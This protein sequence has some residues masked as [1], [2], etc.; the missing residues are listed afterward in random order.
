[1]VLYLLSYGPSSNPVA[2]SIKLVLRTQKMRAD[3]TAPIYLR[4]TAARKSRF[5]STGIAVEPKHWHEDKQEV[6]RTHELADTYNDRLKA[7]KH[8]A[9]GAVLDART[10]DAA[11]KATAPQTGGLSTFFR[12]YIN[13][14]DAKGAFWEWKKYRVTLSKLEAALGTG[15]AFHDLDRA[16]LTRLERYLKTERRNAPNTVRKEMTRLRTVLRRAIKEGHLK[17]AD[18]PFLIYDRPKGE[19]VERRKLT[20]DEIASLAALDLPYGEWL[21]LSRDTFLFSYYG[22]GV[23]FSDMAALRASNL[24]DGRVEYRMLK[25][26]HLVSMPLPPPA[27]AIAQPYLDA[28]PPGEGDAFLFGLL[29]P[30]DGADPVKL[31]RKIG[32]RN[33]Q[34]NGHLKTLAT[35]AGIDRPETV[36]FH[37]ARHSF[38]DFARTKSGN[39][40]AISKA[41]GHSSLSV[42]QQYL[43]SFD[44]EAVDG[45]AADMWK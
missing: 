8:E 10:P 14:L 42:T 35:E 23:R 27:L 5:R 22:G 45:L 12:D 2:Y 41:L 19:R 24:R 9:M 31:R 34:V 18:D 7:I 28:L 38:A 40:Y 15:L 36:S 1:M 4:V 17:P 20:P 43:R 44:R 16:A 13:D 29:R 33:A 37:V 11:L 30:G 21:R 39:L 6:R 3:G 25:T 32:S 26:A